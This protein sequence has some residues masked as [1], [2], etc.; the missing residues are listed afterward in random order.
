VLSAT[1]VACGHT[2][3]ST[4]LSPFVVINEDVFI[5]GGLYANTYANLPVQPQVQSDWNQT[6]AT[7]VDYIKNKPTIPA[8]Y[9]Q[10]QADWAQAA[11]SA[12]DYIK[13]KPTKLSQFSNDLAL[14]SSFNTRSGAV[15]LTLNDVV[16][17]LGYTPAQSSASGNYT[18]LYLKP[19]DLTVDIPVGTVVFDYLG[20]QYINDPL[21]VKCGTTVNRSDYK[22]LAN[23]LGIPTC[24]NTFN[25]PGPQI[26]YNWLV[27]VPSQSTQAPPLFTGTVNNPV[28]LTSASIPNLMI[29]AGANITFNTYSPNNGYNFLGISATYPTVTPTM[30]SGFPAIATQ[31]YTSGST[32]VG[33][34]VFAAYY[35]NCSVGT[36]IGGSTLYYATVLFGA[37]TSTNQVSSA[38]GFGSWRCQGYCN[39]SQAN[40]TFPS[41]TLWVRI[42]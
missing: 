33:A 30:T 2:I 31:G 29:L 22:Q 7:A 32:D 40:G 9:T 23:A 12:V 14:V 28:P 13:N 17:A 1:S 16:S 37:G 11:T 5:N 25:I 10:Q 35:G 34:Q 27:N 42:A 38:I 21:W 6:N 19:S 4:A 36:V 18:D 39:G 20:N 24:S 15:S 3:E 8:A 26:D 41:A